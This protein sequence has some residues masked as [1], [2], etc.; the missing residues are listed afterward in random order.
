MIM[1]SY[2]KSKHM[3]A[4]A[5]TRYMYVGSVHSTR[6]KKMILSATRANFKIIVAKENR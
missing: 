3:D 2:Y 1:S 4:V 5:Q 6:K